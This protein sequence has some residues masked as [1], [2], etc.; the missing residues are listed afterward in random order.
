MTQMVEQPLASGGMATGDVSRQEVQEEKV[1]RLT[2]F[3]H[4][5][6]FVLGFSTIFTLLGVVAGVV[7]LTISDWLQRVGAVIL[8]L[9]ALT[10]LGIFRWAAQRIRSSGN[11]ESNP[12]IQILLAVFDFFNNLLYSERRVV[13][14]HSVNKNWG[15]LSSFVIGLS[16]GAGWTPCV[17]PILGSI[18]FLAG[19]SETIG[20]ATILMAMYSIGLGIPFLM[21]GAAFSQASR[22]LRYLNQYAN[23]VGI[24]SGILLLGIAYLLWTGELTS[25]AGQFQS[26]NELAYTL[27]EWIA[28]SFGSGGSII[29]AS[30]IAAAPVAFLAGVISFVSPCV[31]PLV[32]A[33][34]GYLSGATLNN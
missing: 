27:E 26:L 22:F 13:E 28:V 10:T 25:L 7:G 15:Y 17:G 12:A 32:P 6:A 9:L 11:S 21:V 33:Y 4:A 3:L 34:I 5:L 14:I 18:W 23:I 29:G 1:G 24:V 31:L 30:L 16:F 8:F 2:V 19:T 20:Q